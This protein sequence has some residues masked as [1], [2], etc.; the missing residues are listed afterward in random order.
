[1]RKIAAHADALVEGIG[2][3]ARCTRVLVAECQLVMDEIDDGLHAAPARLYGAELIPRKLAE[4]IGF[5]IAAAEQ[6]D[7][8]VVRQIRNRDLGETLVDEIGL[9]RVANGPA[10]RNLEISRR[11][12]EAPADVSE[13]VTIRRSRNLWRNDQW[14]FVY[15]VATSFIAN[16]E[17]GNERRG[18][19][20]GDGNVEAIIDEHE[21]PPYRN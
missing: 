16:I 5:T 4:P 12:D 8:N 20:D 6:V 21:T 11:R 13:L 2:C 9:A 3:G 15:D 19:R 7:E 17:Q 18:L 14:A 1:M 10:A